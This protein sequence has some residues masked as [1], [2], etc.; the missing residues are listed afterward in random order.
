[1]YM[2]ELNELRIDKYNEK[3]CILVK[4]IPFC[5]FN[6]DMFQGIIMFKFCFTIS[7]YV[8][9]LNIRINYHTHCEDTN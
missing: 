2:Y 3:Y 4:L 7:I 9:K 8:T 5:S 1:M 6:F